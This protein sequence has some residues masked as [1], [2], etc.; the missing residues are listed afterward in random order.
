MDSFINISGGN[1]ASAARP[2]FRIIGC[3][4]IKSPVKNKEK[5]PERISGDRVFKTAH[6]ERRDSL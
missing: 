4:M 2:G 5:S 6:K 3:V 1:P